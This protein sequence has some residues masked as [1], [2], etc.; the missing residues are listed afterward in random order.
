MLK[1]FYNIEGDFINKYCTRENMQMSNG[2]SWKKDNAY[3]YKCGLNGME[4]D[5]DDEGVTAFC[6]YCALLFVR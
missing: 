5:I 1:Y 6:N 2:I 4:K 3:S